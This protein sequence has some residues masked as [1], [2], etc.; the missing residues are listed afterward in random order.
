VPDAQLW[1]IPSDGSG[2]ARQLTVVAGRA[3]SWPKWDP[4]EYLNQG[5]PLFWMSWSSRRAY[6]LRIAE[7]ARAQL[8]MA[9]FEP[10]V[11]ATGA[12]GFRPAFR[13]PFQDL[14]TSNHIAQ[15]VTS[16]ERQACRDNGDCGGEFCVDG[17]CF[18][19]EPLL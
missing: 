14:E 9:A 18:A 19:E 10:T 5:R 7:D 6:G 13:L 2:A 11:A 3:D 8:W 12:Q 17:R 16:V 15:W 4:T 1:L